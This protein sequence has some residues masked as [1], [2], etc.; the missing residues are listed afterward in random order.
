[1]PLVKI[2]IPKAYTKAISKFQVH[3]TYSDLDMEPSLD[4]CS[5]FQERSNSLNQSDINYRTLMSLINCI[6][7]NAHHLSN[8]FLSD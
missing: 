1:M 7:K 4:K 5:L 6:R 2:A 3:I 8:G